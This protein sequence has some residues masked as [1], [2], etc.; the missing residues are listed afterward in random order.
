MIAPGCG[1]GRKV[2]TP[3]GSALGNTQGAR[4]YGKCHRKDTA[5]LARGGRGKGEKVG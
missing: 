2:R 1:R 4:A 5:A 3:Q